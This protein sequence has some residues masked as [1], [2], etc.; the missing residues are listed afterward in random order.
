MSNKHLSSDNISETSKKGLIKSKIFLFLAF[1]E[2]V[3]III[4]MLQP[5]MTRIFLMLDYADNPDF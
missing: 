2:L 4:R 5:V 1:L 3:L